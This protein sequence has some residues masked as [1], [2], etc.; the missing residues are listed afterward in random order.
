MQTYGERLQ[1][2]ISHDVLPQ[3]KLLPNINNDNNNQNGEPCEQSLS[4]ARAD[5]LTTACHFLN[6]SHSEL[7]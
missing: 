3:I 6:L 2:A 5:E 1:S 4:P 7:F